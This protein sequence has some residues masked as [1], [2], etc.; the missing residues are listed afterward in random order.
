MASLHFFMQSSTISSCVIPI[1]PLWRTWTN[2][3]KSIWP[4]S[5]NN[6]K[7]PHT[8][9]TMIS[10]SSPKRHRTNR[11]VSCWMDGWMDRRDG[12]LAYWCTMKTSS[13]ICRQTLKNPMEA[14]VVWQ[15]QAWL[16]KNKWNWWC[17]S[18][19]KAESLRMLGAAGLSPRVQRHEN[20]ELR[21][22]RTGEGHASSRRERM[23][24]IFLC[25]FGPVWAF[26][27]LAIV[28]S[29]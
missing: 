18:Q 24:L 13:L 7:T 3:S 6:N 17:E 12:I 23:D 28:H 8:G 2:A 25:P 26:R 16:L 29:H 22:S 20:I 14:M 11:M 15:S 10:Q 5:G 1:D 21:Y 27:S 4:L 9:T 19:L